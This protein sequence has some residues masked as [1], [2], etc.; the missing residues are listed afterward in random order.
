[1]MNEHGFIYKHPAPPDNIVC[2]YGSAQPVRFAQ[3][4]SYDSEGKEVRCK[5]GKL[6]GSAIVSKSAYVAK[7]NECMEK[8]ACE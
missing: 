1:M 5:C 3:G 8:E 4:V 6:A 2:E 7:C